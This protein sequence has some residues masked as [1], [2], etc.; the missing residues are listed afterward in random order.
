MLL[1]HAHEG[2]TTT[3]SNNAVG[4]DDGSDHPR[5]AA[6]PERGGLALRGSFGDGD[7][8]TYHRYGPTLNQEAQSVIGM[9]SPVEWPPCL[10]DHRPKTRRRA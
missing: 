9:A 2:A 7:L 8:L 4:Y 5:L 10:L 1:G 6:T 3:G